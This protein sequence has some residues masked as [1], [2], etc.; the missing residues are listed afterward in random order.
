MDLQ[1]MHTRQFDPEQ[2]VHRL[3]RIE[4]EE[5]IGR[6]RYDVAQRRVLDM[7]SVHTEKFVGNKCVHRMQIGQTSTRDFRSADQLST[8]Y[9]DAGQQ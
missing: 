5:H 9:L 6:G 2:S 3:R 1:E 7:R 8:V 4:I